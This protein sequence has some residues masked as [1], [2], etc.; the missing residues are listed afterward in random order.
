METKKT[1]DIFVKS[2]HKDFKLLQ[3]SL[4]SLAKNITGYNN[5]IILIPEKEKEL[6][7]TRVL[8]ER[9]LIHY[10]KE[11]GNG[12]LFQQYCKLSAFKY[13]DAEFIMFSDSDLIF[14]KPINLQDYI[15]DGKPEILYT[16]YSKV[17][18]AIC[19]KRSTESL[20]GS[21]VQY[22]FMRR[23][24]LIYHRST[25][26]NISR[27]QPNLQYIVMNSKSFSEFNLMGAYACK[28]ENDKYN[29]VNTDDWQFVP[30]KCEQLWSWSEKDNE[31]PTHKYEYQRTIDTINKV[32][33]LNITE[34]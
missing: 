3:Y 4:L 17:G 24:A 1:C 12:Y 20:M 19:W 34:I 26:E 30:A 29:F 33:G 21:P 9:T 13:S 7:D 10:V 23:N 16:D 32:L 28:F 6:F 25:L 22:E 5:V 14:D 31:D 8:P 27:W 2:Y 18:D 15:A 11:H